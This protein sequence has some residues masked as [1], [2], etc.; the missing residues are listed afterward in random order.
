MKSNK[1]INRRARNTKRSNAKYSLKR[2]TKSQKVYRGGSNDNPNMHDYDYDYYTQITNLTNDKDALN[3]KIK[4]IQNDM[5][6]ISTNI[7]YNTATEDV[8][9]QYN[10]YIIDKQELEKKINLINY[11]IYLFTQAQQLQ[12]N[13][14]TF[15]YNK[16][17]PYSSNDKKIYSNMQTQLNTINGE[18]DKVRLMN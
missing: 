13:I 9:T 7:D 5:Q 3:K 1:S 14:T 6:L 4:Y 15:F 17:K 16:S 2:S 11:K 18:I 8:K 10:K 12:E